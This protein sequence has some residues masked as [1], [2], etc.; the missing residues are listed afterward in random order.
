L[1]LSNCRTLQVGRYIQLLVCSIHI[2]LLHWYYSCG[3][4]RINI[5]VSVTFSVLR[6]NKLQSTHI[7]C[8]PLSFICY[9]HKIGKWRSSTSSWHVQNH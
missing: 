2:Q 7:K 3:C 6:G 4:C 5:E 8:R 9:S 1:M